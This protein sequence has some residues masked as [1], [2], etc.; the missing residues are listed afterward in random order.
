[1]EFQSI[2]G[3][4][5]FS[6]LK[7][8]EKVMPLF[9]YDLNL[10]Q[11][12]RDI[13][14][15]R[16]MYQLEQYFYRRPEVEEVSYRQEVLKDMENPKVYQSIDEFSYGMRKAK[17]YLVNSK[18]SENTIQQ[19]KWKLDTAYYYIIT[20]NRLCEDLDSLTFQSA[21]LRAFHKWLQDYR[22][23]D[24]YQQL[25]VA[26]DELIGKFNEMRFSLE[27]KSERINVTLEY[28]EDD[29][30][31]QLLDIFKKQTSTEHYYQNNPFGTIA[32]SSLEAAVL[33]ILRKYYPQVFIELKNYYGKYNDFISN[34][35]ETFETEIQ[36]YISFIK[37]KSEM[38]EMRFHFCYP[39]VGSKGE[40]AITEG[41]DLALARKNASK[42]KDVIYNDCRIESGEQFLVITGPNQGGKT[43]YARA[44]GQILYFGMMGL[45]VPARTAAFPAFDDIYTHFATEESMETGAGKL[46][47]ELIRL[48]KLMDRATG[49]SFVII[50]EIFTSA[51]SYDAYI[52]GKRVLEYFMKEQCLG[53]YVTHIYELTKEDDRI[54]S[55]VASLLSED[56][57]VRTFKIER[58]KADGRSYANTI[59]EKYH[60][61]YEE[62]KERIKQ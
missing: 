6:Q 60:M 4:S 45:M 2:L 47:E 38:E 48:K 17:E 27:V 20:L 34:V 51:T 43:T 39:R 21:G 12:V 33:G 28:I 46:K 23:T 56:S 57:N 52:M 58:R 10:D 35:I 15:Q 11:I 49:N 59:V 19:H 24:E 26:T 13:M 25:T 53:V 55:M 61:T 62:I 9:F 5:R 30:C 36:F 18:E 54:V 50:N 8:E 29:Y 42:K 14:D 31:K 1:M 37:Y 7:A 41:Y 22:Q 40:F 32:L 16:K 44:L 3:V